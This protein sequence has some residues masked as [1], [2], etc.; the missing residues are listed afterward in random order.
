MR[1]K[2]PCASSV[3]SSVVKLPAA[4]VLAGQHPDHY[5]RYLEETFPPHSR[6][7]EYFTP[8]HRKVHEMEGEK[9]GNLVAKWR[10][11]DQR[12]AD[13]LFRRYADR[14]VTLAR[15]KLPARLF[16]RVDAEDVVQSVYRSFFAGARDGQY[17][18]RQGGDLWRLLVAI[19]LHKLYQQVRRNTAGKRDVQR[20][21]GFAAST[22][23]DSLTD[24]VLAHE[25]SPIEAV[26]LTDQL[27]MVMRRLEPQHRRI[28]ELRLQGYNLHEIA[29]QTRRCE[30]TV[31]R[32]LDGIKE[33]LQHWQAQD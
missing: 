22:D 20:E 10:A 9:S 27:E 8:H 7:V 11:G 31:R 18:P 2:K 4:T 14:L 3:S 19:T 15:S 28:L 33:H 13:E 21:H 32:V 25:P 26:A 30:R 6:R 16:R 1:S 23:L 24:R 5:H 12:A 29:A 17:D